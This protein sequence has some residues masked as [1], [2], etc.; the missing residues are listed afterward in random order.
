[1]KPD[2]NIPPVWPQTGCHSEEVRIGTSVSLAERRGI[3]YPR[4][5]SHSG[6]AFSGVSL[7]PLE[8][9]QLETVTED[10]IEAATEAVSWL[11]G[12]T[13]QIIEIGVAVG[14]IILLSVLALRVLKMAVNRAAQRVMTRHDQPARELKLKA[15]TLASVIENAGRIVI[16][17]IATMMVL[18]NVGLDIGPLLASAG[19]VGLAVG[20]GAQ[21]LIRDFISGFFILLED[22]FGVGDVVTI[23]D[24]SGTVEHLSL[25]RTAM[26]TIDG[27]VVTIPNGEILQVS[28]LTKGWARAVLDIDISYGDDIDKAI[29]VIEDELEGIETDEKIGD[30]VIAPAEVLGVIALGAWQVT[31]RAWV[32][33]K[34][35]EQWGVQR[36]LFKRLKQALDRNDI[37]IPFPHQVTLV[38]SENGRHEAVDQLL[39]QESRQTSGTGSGQ[40]SASQESAESNEPDR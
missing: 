16:L 7:S 22:Q 5:S 21:S 40:V 11:A 32:K 14:V 25:R 28:N 29:Q 9:P 20:F 38:R 3:R 8:L 31:I 19:V 39:G 1:M 17:L 12:F 4:T 15:D 18:S 2:S 30:V 27:T 35:M 6:Y 24:A 34:P 36:E 13:S 10:P 26:R 33:T 37:T 23:N